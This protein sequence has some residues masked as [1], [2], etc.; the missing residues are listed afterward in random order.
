MVLSTLFWVILEGCFAFK[1]PG[2][3]TGRCGICLHSIV[4]HFLERIEFQELSMIADVHLGA[5]PYLKVPLTKVLEL[6][7]VAWCS[8]FLEKPRF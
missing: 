8:H 5:L 6:A 4:R 1:K 3:T 7:R 2:S